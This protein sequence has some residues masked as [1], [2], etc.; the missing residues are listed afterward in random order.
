MPLPAINIIHHD[1]PLKPIMPQLRQH[2]RPNDPIYATSDDDS[3]TND[4]VEVVRQRLVHAVT[5]GG[6]YE[7][8]DRQVDVA[9]EEEDGDR[10]GGFDGRIPLP[11]CL[12][13]V[14]VD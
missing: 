5:V 9:E 12:V 3:D 14:E 1:L 7:R 4:A 6:W 10:E 11:G 13:Q 8:R 2:D